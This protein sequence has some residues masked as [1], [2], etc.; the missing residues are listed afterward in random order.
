MVNVRSEE[1][2]V[3]ESESVERTRKWYVT[4]PKRSFGR[5]TVWEVTESNCPAVLPYDVSKPNST[6]ESADSFV[7]HVTVAVDEVTFLI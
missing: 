3:F 6:K 7:V 1:T 2:V 5:L 4:S